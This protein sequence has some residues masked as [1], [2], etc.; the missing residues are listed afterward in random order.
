MSTRNAERIPGPHRNAGDR[1][2]GATGATTIAW[3]EGWSVRSVRSRA[4]G[5]RLTAL[6]V[7]SLGLRAQGLGF[8]VEG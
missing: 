3:N 5:L 7:V 4:Q 1:T 6:R 8:R 2:E